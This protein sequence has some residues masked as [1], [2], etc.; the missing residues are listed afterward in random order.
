MEIRKIL[1]RTDNVKY[2]VVPKSSS[3]LNAGDFVI[4]V[5]IDKNNQ[6]L[7][8]YNEL[9]IDIKNLKMKSNEL[10]RKI[11]ITQKEVEENARKRS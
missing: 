2:I 6:N 7:K 3:D 8:A 1:K 5:K 10:K 11:E 4:L 9:I